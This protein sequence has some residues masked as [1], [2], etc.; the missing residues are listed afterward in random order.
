MSQL[1][2]P[3]TILTKIP[4]NGCDPKGNYLE[5]AD[6][7][8]LTIDVNLEI[9]QLFPIQQVSANCA[10]YKFDH[11]QGKLLIESSI[12]TNDNFIIE[13]KMQDKVQNQI[14][15]CGN[16]AALTI[17]PEFTPQTNSFENKEF[18]F[19]IDC[20]A[21][22]IGDSISKAKES[23]NL[24][25]SKLP[26]NS[27]FNIIQFG[28]TFNKLFP[29]A[30]KS[31][32]KT[33]KD[34]RNK[35][36]KIRANLG[37]TQLLEL[38]QELF[39]TDLSNFE[40]KNFQREIFLIT[41][42][43][44]Y[45][46]EEVVKLIEANSEF[47]RIF[48]IG[49]GNGA[50]AGFLDEV[51]EITNGKS[52]FVYDSNDLPNKVIEHLDLS[53][54]EAAKNTEIQLSDQIEAQI[55]P[56]PL[57]LLLPGVA[58]HFFIKNSNSDDIRNA[59]VTSQLS[60]D[61][62]E[63][64]IVLNDD[65]ILNAS[66]EKGGKNPI[67]S[68]FAHK[69]LNR[70]ERK[71]EEE[72][73]KLSLESGVL[74]KY[75]S[76]VGVSSVV[77]NSRFNYIYDRKSRMYHSCYT[78]YGLSCDP[79]LE[80]MTFCREDVKKKSSLWRSFGSLLSGLCFWRRAKSDKVDEPPASISSSCPAKLDDDGDDSRHSWS[81][82]ASVVDIVKMQSR[83]GFW[84]ISTKFVSCHFGDDKEGEAPSIGFEIDNA[85][86]MKR[87]RS[88]VFVLAYLTKYHSKDEGMWNN[89]KEKALKWLCKINKTARW[90]DSISNFIE[91]LQRQSID[92]K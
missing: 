26:S 6:L 39:Q 59:L 79:S 46:R 73:T 43:E 86:I 34:A 49:L 89:S 75:T 25:L 24:F 8:S 1:A 77:F 82:D 74:C 71:D 37:G 54:V 12:I 80:G 3:T 51:A 60:N 42:G 87:V 81:N 52:D 27:M 33:I 11:N 16:M 32:P 57:P 22:M 53:L 78:G 68:L 23:I 15:K 35:V 36:S 17:I 14:V 47:N 63:L 5:L 31:N 20:S 44:I 18:I 83:D 92:F 2:T 13:I 72:S 21:S 50:D 64:E 65:S 40:N 9:K 66:I 91:N 45:M 28:S 76:Y 19:L 30:I 69:L 56:F 70:I 84:D 7:P 62:D 61:E 41:D 29:T 58:R 85:M 67:L 38:F 4:L 88:T 48:A 90:E 55:V 10:N